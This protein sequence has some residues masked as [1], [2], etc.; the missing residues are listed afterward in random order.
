M[1][2]SPNMFFIYLLWPLLVNDMIE[3]IDIK[4]YYLVA[5]FALFLLAFLSAL[6][7][8]F[9]RIN[10]LLWHRHKINISP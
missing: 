10:E 7:K 3:K 9:R 6:G 5:L 2:D 8:K 4:A 1:Y